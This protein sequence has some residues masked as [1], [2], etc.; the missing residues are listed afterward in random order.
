MRFI[1]RRLAF[2]VATAWIA[3]TINFIIPRLMPGNP[4]I[5]LFNWLRITAT[6]GAIKAFDIAFGV[7]TR[8][9]L[10]GQYWSYLGQ[11][12]HGNLGISITYYPTTVGS[13]IGQALPWTVALLGVA[14]VLSF[15]IG[16]LLGMFSATRRGSVFA[17]S[18][19]PVTSLLSAIPYF[20]LGLV[21]LTFFAVDLG[22][23]PLN[24]GSNPGV[25]IGLSWAFMHS[26]RLPFQKSLP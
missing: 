8:E 6:P 20:W 7:S 19:V 26:A 15:L 23:F 10:T 24:G 16:T 13:V 11:L 14:T 2:Y 17:D 12:A 4:V 5:E 21:V 18:L 9:G 1:L 22:W 3:I 25:P